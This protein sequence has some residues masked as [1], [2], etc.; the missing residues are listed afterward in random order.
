MLRAALSA[1]LSSGRS[2]EYERS[3]SIKAAGCDALA[4]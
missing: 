2:L 3:S 1:A 4:A